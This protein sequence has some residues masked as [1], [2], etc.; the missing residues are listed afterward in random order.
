M[1][2]LLT[3]FNWCYYVATESYIHIDF[4]NIYIA[5]SKYSLISNSNYWNRQVSWN[6]FRKIRKY[7]GKLV[8]ETV[9]LISL[10]LHFP[11]F[12]LKFENF[13]ST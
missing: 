5:C 7:L 2:C 6:K 8:Y 4:E 3:P 1:F 11:G 10:I 13:R 9:F 12:R